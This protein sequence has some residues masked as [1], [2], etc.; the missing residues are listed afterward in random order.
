MKV[1]EISAGADTNARVHSEVIGQRVK[2][3]Y[4][5]PPGRWEYSSFEAGT[6][7][8]E[9]PDYSADW[10]A[11]EGVVAALRARGCYVTF[12]CAPTGDWR[13]ILEWLPDSRPSAP[14]S[15]RS[16]AA[17]APLALCR[18]ALAANDRL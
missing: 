15:V 9:V 17:N 10:A 18:A 3:Q 12:Q 16:E 13:A 6:P 14:E 11:M 7:F 2:Y 5:V 1:D 4:H 8:D